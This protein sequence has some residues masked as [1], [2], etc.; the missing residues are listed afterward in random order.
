MLYC[1]IS[2]LFQVA[3]TSSFHMSFFYSTSHFSWRKFNP[4]SYLPQTLT[5]IFPGIFYGAAEGVKS[6]KKA[7]KLKKNFN[8]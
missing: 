7:E 5:N 8:C 3:S 6:R 4:I 2:T 1:V